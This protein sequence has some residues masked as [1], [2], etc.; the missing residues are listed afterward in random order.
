MRRL[1]LA[2]LLLAFLAGCASDN[3]PQYA[4]TEHSD[5]MLVKDNVAH[6]QCCL[7]EAINANYESWHKEKV[8]ARLMCIKPCLLD[9]NSVEAGC[10]NNV[11]AVVHLKNSTE[12]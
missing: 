1:L 11:C 9:Q 7:W 12:E 6:N 3:P 5:C 4:C 8:S 10:F 2:L